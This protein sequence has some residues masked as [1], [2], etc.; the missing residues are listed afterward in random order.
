MIDV[1]R[2]FS[3]HIKLTYQH[4]YM[5]ISVKHYTNILWSKRKCVM[6]VKMY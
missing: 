1:N 3:L 5:K 6:I 2:N 4:T